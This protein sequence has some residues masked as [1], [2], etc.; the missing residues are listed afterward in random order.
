[1]DA[2]YPLLVTRMS[3]R[4]FSTA[5]TRAI[6]RCCCGAA[7][8]PNQPSLEMLTSKFRAVGGE[9]ANFVRDKW[10]RSR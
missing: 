8:R 6:S 3:Q 2:V 9:A 7:E 1:M 5:R 10:L 4:R